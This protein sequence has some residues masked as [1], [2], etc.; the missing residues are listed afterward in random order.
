MANKKIKNKGSAIKICDHCFTPKYI[1]FNF[2]YFKPDNNF[3]GHEG[4]LLKRM[5]EL[6]AEDYLIII[7]KPK[8]FGFEFENVNIGKEIPK[9]FKNR[10]E[11]KKYSKFA[12]MR[13]YTNNNP[14]MARVVG[15]IINKIF[16]V[17]YVFVGETGYKR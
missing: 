12:I 4:Q 14:V 3:K 1:K 7:N 15:I 8:E 5:I 11:E 9:E 13:L 10:F 6:S 16:Y 2:S 17:F